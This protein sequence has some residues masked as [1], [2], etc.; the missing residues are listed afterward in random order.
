[1]PCARVRV[2]VLLAASLLARAA[3]AER[4]LREGRGRQRAAPAVGLPFRQ[5]LENY[6]EVQYHGSL[7]LGGQ[8]IRAIYDTGSFDILV[9]STRC[10]QCRGAVYN[11]GASPTFHAYG[12]DV[13]EHSFG[14]GPTESALGSEV[15]KIGPLVAQNQTIHEILKHDMPVLENASFDAI[16][17]IGPEG[18]SA[19]R[20]GGSLLQNLG[21]SEYSICLGRSPGSP[22]WL[23]WGGGVTPAQKA[24]SAA[25]RVVGRHHWAVSMRNL[26]PDVGLQGERRE[27]AGTLLCGRGCAAILDSGTSLIAGPSHS[28][29]GLSYLLPELHE[30]CSNFGDLPDLELELSGRRLRLPPEAYVFRLRGTAQEKR[31]AGRLL[32]SQVRDAADE[33]TCVLGF[34]PMDRHTDWGPLWVLGMPFF[35]QFHVTFGLAENVSE[36]RIWLSRASSSCGALPL[37]AKDVGSENSTYEG[38]GVYPKV[39]VAQRWQSRRPSKPRVI[40]A[41]SL[42]RSR[43]AGDL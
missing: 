27:A 3:V 23:T 31:A 37:E 25:L 6:E 2:A 35:R 33:D 16:V 12:G 9:V 22:G 18:D 43:I 19:Q 4:L 20:A 1:M 11:P 10:P 41:S 36:R 15:V 30:N 32:L 42:L 24:S 13:V 26:L 21:I 7:Q 38:V 5:R 28:L 8:D 34:L 17:G 29:Q 40:R 39:V 14:S